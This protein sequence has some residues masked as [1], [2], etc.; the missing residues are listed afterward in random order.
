VSQTVIQLRQSSD[1]VACA[2][3]RHEQL[4]QE[5]ARGLIAR[6]RRHPSPYEVTFSG[7][8]LMMLPEVFCPAYGEGSQLLASL[9]RAASQDRILDMGTGS[10]ALGLLAASQ[11]AQVVATDIS[12]RAVECV[13]LNGRRLQLDSRVDV[14]HGDLFECI[15]S[16]ETFSLVL[17][18]LPFMEGEPQNLLEVA[19]YDPQWRT[20]RGFF[21]ELATHL[22]PNGRALVAFSDCGDIDLLKTVCD[23]NKL[24][25]REVNRMTLTLGFYVYE[26]TRRRRR[27]SLPDAR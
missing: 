5:R 18:N 27:T 20:M 7:L 15:G 16:D 19:M 21:E 4:V 23:A 12:E 25:A 14:R 6:H 26:I 10:G 13:R 2:S 17:F 24:D 1:Y 9:I 22:T 8:E 3:S 11:G